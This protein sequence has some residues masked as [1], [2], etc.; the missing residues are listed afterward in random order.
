MLVADT[1]KKPSHR[2]PS[3]GLTNGQ[4]PPNCAAFRLP[5]APRFAPAPDEVVAKVDELLK[6]VSE[7]LGL[8]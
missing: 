4:V 1:K 3:G 7:G 2:P 6:G 5:F 8:S